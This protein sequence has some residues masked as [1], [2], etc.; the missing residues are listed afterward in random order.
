MHLIPHVAQLVANIF[1]LFFSF[2]PPES[3]SPAFMMFVSLS[4]L[5]RSIDRS[6]ASL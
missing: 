4:N 5:P 2:F 1:A 3:F 6:I